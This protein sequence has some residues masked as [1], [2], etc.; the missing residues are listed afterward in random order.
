MFVFTVDDCDI[1]KVVVSVA[2][3]YLEDNAT[4]V[5]QPSFLQTDCCLVFVVF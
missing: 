4:E 5:R 1:C 2:D 3:A